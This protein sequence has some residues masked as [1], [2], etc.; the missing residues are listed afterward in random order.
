M[1]TL[2]LAQWTDVSDIIK[3]L[4][5][6]LHSVMEPV[7]KRLAKNYVYEI[8]LP[9]GTDLIKKGMPRIFDNDFLK[10]C[11]FKGGKINIDAESFSRD[12]LNKNDHPLGLIQNGIVEIYESN[13]YKGMDKQICYNFPLNI[14]RGGDILG[15]FGATD[16][17]FSSQLDKQ[18][19]TYS[20]FCGNYCIYPLLPKE[21]DGGSGNT[22]AI[23]NDLCNEYGLHFNKGE[24]LFSYFPQILKSFYQASQE[25][26]KFILI[27]DFWYNSPTPQ[28]VTLRALISKIA[29]I[30]SREVRL[31]D[32]GIISTMTTLNLTQSRKDHLFSEM[33]AYLDGAIG[34]KRLL[35]MPVKKGSYPYDIYLSLKE[36][37]QGDYD[38]LLFH[39]DFIRPGEWGLF[40][41]F[42]FPT[43]NPIDTITN[44]KQFLKDFQAKV[45]RFYKAS[46]TLSNLKYY[47]SPN[48]FLK[49]RFPDRNIYSQLFLIRATLIVELGD[50]S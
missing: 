29:W 5:P 6:A 42:T 48:E 35:L 47:F 9:L 30:Q 1:P 16:L 31:N 22:R 43:I 11:V 12:F 18:H 32:L 24:Q 13:S 40:P 20:A 19:Y 26:I 41:L 46:P 14:L 34:G 38:P 7:A 50:I 36:R 49:N 45:D 37:F 33:I 3:S 4:N 8:E 28:N 27:P 2:Y 39:F 10:N 21:W 25:T 23:V 17:I 15:T 44:G